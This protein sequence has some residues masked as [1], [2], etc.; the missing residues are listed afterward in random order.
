MNSKA[1]YKL[2]YGLYV[3]GSHKGDKINAQIANT[4][5]QITSE[6]PTVAVSINKNNLTHEYI[7]ESK[8][9]AASVLSTDTPVSF[10]GNFG[11]KSGRDTDKFKGV[12]YKIGVTGSPIVLDNA[13][14]YLEVKVTQEVDEGTHTIY[15]GQV[16]DADILME[17]A[18]MTYEFYQQVKHGT[19]PKNAPSYQAPQPETPAA[20]APPSV[21]TVATPVTSGPSKEVSKLA[22]YKC[23]VCGWIYDPAIGDPDGGINPGTPF[24]EIPDNWVC[25]ICGAAKSQF[26]KIG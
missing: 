11:F 22:K 20:A 10:I 25:P 5:F 19:T 13:V 12:Q 26:D 16:V 15:I 24:E 14:S 23:Q 18:T 9:F 6:P 7:H 2:G 1:L 8:S 21:P 3:V 4:V 17:K